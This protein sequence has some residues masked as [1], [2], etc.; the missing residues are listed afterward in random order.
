MKQTNRGR[1]LILSHHL[2]LRANAKKKCERVG[3]AW[4]MNW[5]ELNF[6]EPHPI[7]DLRKGRGLSPRELEQHFDHQD[8]RQVRNNQASVK[9]YL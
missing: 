9:D 8:R 5:S 7:A 3:W 4:A 1:A 6:R 2:R